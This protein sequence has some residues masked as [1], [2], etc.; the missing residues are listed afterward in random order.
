MSDVYH[1][2]TTYRFR[3]GPGY[4][5]QRLP[6]LLSVTVEDVMAEEDRVAA[7]VSMRGIHL[8]EFQGLAP[9]GKRVE[10]IR[11]S[12]CSMS[13]VGR[14]WSTGETA[15]IRLT[16]RTR[17]VFLTFPERQLSATHDLA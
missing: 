14:S 11:P 1:L 4:A 9:I 5:L 6:W 10:D 8:G 7:R 17:L 13:P 2:F 16:S 15:T 12:T 3:A